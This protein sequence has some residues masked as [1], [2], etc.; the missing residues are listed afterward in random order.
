M[1]ASMQES[2]NS[3]PESP[4]GPDYGELVGRLRAGFASERTF[5]EQWRQ[6]QLT[7]LETMLLTHEDAFLDALHDDLGKPAMEIGRAHV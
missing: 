7:A 4:A 5:D 3:E 2:T 1:N 6:S